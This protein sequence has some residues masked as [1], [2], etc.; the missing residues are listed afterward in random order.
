MKYWSVLS[1]LFVA[2]AV[3][4]LVF[5]VTVQAIPELSLSLFF[6]DTSPLAAIFGGE[7]V[8]S[9][10]WNPLYG[11]VRLMGLTAAF[12]L[13]LGLSL[14]IY[15]SE[16]ANRRAERVILVLL[17][18]MSGLPSIVI[19]LFGFVLIIFLHQFIDAGT[20]MLLSAF[21][22]AILV[23]PVLALNMYIAMRSLPAELRL[24][25]ASLGMRKEVAIVYIFLSAGMEA[26]LSGC[27]LAA[28]RCAEDTA[29]ILLTGVVA[30][31]HATGIFDKFEALPFFIYYTS[32]NYRDEAELAQVFV[33]A[34]VLLALTA[35]LVLAGGILHRKVR[36]S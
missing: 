8:W 19:G 28:A 22:M 2:F 12:A 20:G 11:T 33:A 16:Y 32:A 3:L 17:E 27:L 30:S 29:V 25:A 18:S 26:I 31:S 6:D 36:G 14:G 10:L 13:P 4:A 9:G 5:F 23:L 24:T 34:F 7:L 35:L 15:L 21:C 1:S